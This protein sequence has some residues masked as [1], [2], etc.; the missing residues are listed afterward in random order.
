VDDVKLDLRNGL[1]GVERW[2]TRGLDRAEWVLRG[3]PR[4]NVEGCIPKEGEEE[5]NHGNL[6][7]NAEQIR[8]FCKVEGWTHLC[9]ISG[10]HSC[11]KGKGKT[12]LLQA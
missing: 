2:R 11:V 8:N 10:S 9:E 7:S 1:M 12:I 6:T 3:K 5:R 4:P